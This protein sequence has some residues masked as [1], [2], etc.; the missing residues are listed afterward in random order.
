MTKLLPSIIQMY[1]Y[2]K[3]SWIIAA[4]L[5]T[6]SA[7]IVPVLVGS[8]YA[9]YVGKLHIFSAFVCL[10]AA[11]FIQIG[12]NFV[13]DLFDFR[14]GADTKERLGPT[15]TIQAG[16]LTQK[17]MMVGIVLVFGVAILCGAYLAY[18]GGSVIIVLGVVSILSGIAYTAGPYPLGYHGLGDIFVF[19]FF[20]MVAVCGTVYVQVQ[21]VSSTAILISL[22]IG[23]LTTAILVVNNVRD[24]NTDRQVGKK[25]LV[26]RWGRLFGL[27]EYF[28]LMALSYFIPLLLKGVGR[29][30]YLSLLP[31]LT[32]PFAVL[33]CFQLVQKNGKELNPVLVKTAQLLLLYGV[34]W[35]VGIGISSSNMLN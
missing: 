24:E 4:R 15:R 22:P 30:G 11:C 17:Q 19:V 31:L 13:N 5:P 25:T 2:K 23:A 3:R 26:A 6:L 35:A 21:S 33:L 9:R 1:F 10:V 7:A 32:F 12:T 16:L 14:K 34:L 8:A 28:L 18:I 20:G 29:F 27:I